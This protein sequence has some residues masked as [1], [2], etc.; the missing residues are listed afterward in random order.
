[1]TGYIVKRYSNNEVSYVGWNSLVDNIENARIFKTKKAARRER[2]QQE[3]Y[4]DDPF[5]FFNV[6]KPDE[7]FTVEVV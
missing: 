4:W 5:G 2:Y 7:I 3:H 1:M 6:G